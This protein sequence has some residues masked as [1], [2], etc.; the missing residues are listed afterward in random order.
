MAPWDNVGIEE[1]KESFSEKELHAKFIWDVPSFCA[2]KWKSPFHVKL[3][4]PS[5]IS[6]YFF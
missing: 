3:L 6:M 2:K 4:I 1:E 5:I